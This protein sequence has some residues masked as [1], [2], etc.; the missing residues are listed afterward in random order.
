MTT[1]MDSLRPSM[2]S[3][4]RG[5]GFCLGAAAPRDATATTTATTTPHSTV[6]R[7]AVEQSDAGV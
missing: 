4:A 7:I 5:W 6:T 1:C 2:V 3:V